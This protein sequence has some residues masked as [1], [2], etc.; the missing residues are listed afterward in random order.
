MTGVDP[1]GSKG[2]AKQAVQG[3]EEGFRLNSKI[4]MR[5]KLRL[6]AL[7]LRSDAS[8][9]VMSMREKEVMQK[10]LIDNGAGSVEFAL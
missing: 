4:G 8:S 5:E 2:S 10:M 7:A 9:R 3:I 6:A 1:D